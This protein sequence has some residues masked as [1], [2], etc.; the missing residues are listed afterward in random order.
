[1][2]PRGRHHYH[3]GVVDGWVG[4]LVA[5][6]GGWEVKGRGIDM[7]DKTVSKI[8]EKKIKFLKMKERKHLCKCL[9]HA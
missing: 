5:G 3:W 9:W 8:I 6:M 1:M 4:G 2:I 7:S